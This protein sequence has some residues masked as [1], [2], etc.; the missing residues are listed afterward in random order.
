[1]RLMVRM[2]SGPQSFLIE[3]SVSKHL[4]VRSINSNETLQEVENVKFLIFE[5]FNYLTM[6]TS[7]TMYQARD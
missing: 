3:S 6:C 2:I 1:M 5:P 7:L 4:N